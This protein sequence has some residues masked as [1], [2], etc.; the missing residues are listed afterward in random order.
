M[1]VGGNREGGQP[2]DLPLQSTEILIHQTVGQPQPA[3]GVQGQDER[4]VGG[5]R[6]SGRGL[7]AA[8]VQEQAGPHLPA[9]PRPPRIAGQ[10]PSAIRGKV[11]VIDSTGRLG[12]DAKG[13]CG[14]YFRCF[15]S[16]WHAA[17]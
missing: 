16:S 4:P 17:C 13:V 11:Q 9:A 6:D 15:R 10:Q 5:K 1:R 8:A 7:G 12:E 2:V 3:V 14:R